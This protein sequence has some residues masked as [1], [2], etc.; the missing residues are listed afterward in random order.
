MPL[1]PKIVERGTALTKGMLLW[2]VPIEELT[3]EELIA[4]IGVLQEGEMR[5]REESL[6][7]FHVKFPR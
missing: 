7:R 4:A 6:Q 3:K 1:P 5:R 2:G